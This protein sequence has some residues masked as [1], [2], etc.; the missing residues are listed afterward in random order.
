LP[1]LLA[2]ALLLAMVRGAT[3]DADVG[4]RVDT[5]SSTV[6]AVDAPS[7]SRVGY[8]VA[9]E[10]QAAVTGGGLRL[11]AA[12]APRV[13]SVDVAQRAP[14]V[15]HSLDARLATFHDAPWSAELGAGATR[16]TTDPLTDPLRG[17]G[18]AHVA[19]T[20]PLAFDAARADTRLKSQL[21]ARSAL[22]GG[23]GVSA[24]QGA[25]AAARAI[26]PR[27]DIL[28]G[29]LRGSHRLSERDTLGVGVGAGASRTGEGDAVV[30]ARW[31]SVSASWRRALTPR[32][33]GTIG[34]GAGWTRTDGARETTPWGQFP[35]AEL[36]LLRSGAVALDA[37]ARLAPY[38][39]PLTGEATEMAD[40][41][42]ALRWPVTATA[43]MEAA[44]RG[45]A[46]SD[47]ETAAGGAELRVSWTVRPRLT[48]DAALLATRVHD[49]RPGMTSYSEAGFVVGA[50]WAPALR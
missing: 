15:D 41:R 31:A 44:A 47:R 18:P 42:C 27:Q 32:L 19:S 20:T 9:P 49:A 38:V 36:G 25:D 1:A 14:I 28:A 34:L 30:G 26:I 12:Y 45:S 46:R 5:R 29:D 17:T 39:D 23:V 22:E 33:E 43:A 10:L 50:G 16:G 8:S 7:T 4:L 13:W 37:R 24:M 40:A 48:F 3:A 6:R 11:G 2:P 35:T 21:D